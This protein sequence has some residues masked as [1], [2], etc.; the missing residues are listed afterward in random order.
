VSK[1]LLNS[2]DVKGYT[3]KNDPVKRFEFGRFVCKVTEYDRALFV[4]LKGIEIVY[5]G[6][7]PR[8]RPKL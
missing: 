5:G 7:I 8:L 2:F 3:A 4:M 1:G 6:A